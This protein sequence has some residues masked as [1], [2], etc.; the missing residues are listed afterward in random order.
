[1]IVHYA[2]SPETLPAFVP[3]V[4]EAPGL[5]K[6]EEIMGGKGVKEKRGVDEARAF[7]TGRVRK[8]I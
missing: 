1:V 3:H 7:G 2:K 5:S 4:R 8:K 6:G